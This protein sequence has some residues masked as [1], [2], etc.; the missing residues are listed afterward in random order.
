MNADARL[1]ARQ[2]RDFA[3]ATG[4][5]L[6]ALALALP[7]ARADD[8]AGPAI[9]LTVFPAAL[10]FGDVP[11]GAT[12]YR[13]MWVQNWNGAPVTLGTLS[14]PAPFAIQGDTCSGQTL[15]DG[16]Y[17]LLTAVFA[18][19]AAGSFAGTFAVPTTVPAG[20]QVDVP[21]SGTAAVSVDGACGSASASVLTAAPASALCSAGVASAVYPSASDF[22]WNCAGAGGGGTASCSAQRGYVVTP[23]AGSNGSLS[24]STPQVVAYGNSAVFAI[25]PAPGYDAL[26]A[27]TCGGVDTGPDYYTDAV[28]ADCTVSATFFAMPRL[29]S[30]TV[31][32]PGGKTY[33]DPPFA[34]QGTSSSGLPVEYAALTPTVCT[35]SGS[36][37]SLGMPGT[38]EIAANQGGDAQWLPAPTMLLVF[39]VAR[40][41][42]ALWFEPLADRYLS[43]SPAPLHAIGGV[44][45]YPVAFDSLTP[46]TCAVA[47]SSVT[48]LAPGACTVQASQAGDDRYLPAAI[49]RTFAIYNDER[50]DTLAFAPVTGV[51]LATLVVSDPVIVTGIDYPV[52]VTVTNGE[53]SVGCDGRFGRE[54]A[55]ILPNQR[56]CVRQLSAAT[57]FTGNTTQVSVGAARAEFATTTGRPEPRI[58]VLASR[59]PSLYRA[60]VVFTVQAGGDFG[61]VTG[62]VSLK[63]GGVAVLGCEAVALVDQRG[64]CRTDSL[65]PG[66]RELRARYEGND[67]YAWSE[68]VPRGHYVRADFG[69]DFRD[70]TG[71]GRSALF[72]ETARGGL[73]A[74]TV[75]RTVAGEVTALVDPD[76][77]WHAR[78]FADFDGDGKADVAMM[79]ADGSV[80]IWLLDGTT[81][82]RKGPLVEATGQIAPVL[83]GDFDGDGKD[84][85]VMRDAQGLYS[86]WLMDGLQVKSASA[87]PNAGPD[88]VP[89]AVADFDGD[90]HQD[91]VLRHADGR[92]RIQ[93]VK[94][95]LAREPADFDL[96]GPGFALER[97]GDFNGDN[98]ADLLLRG[99][100]GESIAW[101]MDGT[102]LER[103]LA[104]GEPTD[105]RVVHVADFD[106]DGADD[107]LLA[108]PGG[109]LALWMMDGLRVDRVLVIREPGEVAPWEVSTADATS[110]APAK[111]K[112]WRLLRVA[113]F[114]GDGRP[115]LMLQGDTGEIVVVV[116]DG[117]KVAGWGVIAGPTDWTII[118]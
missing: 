30:L 60:D 49:Q 1:A 72:L 105:W 24:P 115:D 94:D 104:I 29:Q 35:V 23:W 52:A 27:G 83:V 44:S 21:M 6:L 74:I 118:P 76:S 13:S 114:C 57:P 113:D 117:A 100:A 17:C 39:E 67:T 96:P 59:H 8:K 75:D 111:P 56:L 68:S 55:T 108:G 58:E 51:R 22:S 61:P 71:T 45:G 9:N 88:L 33:G 20:A 37:A 77:G 65:A 7:A 79:H 110:P 112:S 92:L 48:T 32:A 91:L 116:L 15:G 5:L 81:K 50:P 36:V 25:H 93:P 31:P 106:T 69:S 18:P 73:Q 98:K 109:G 53:F 99:P 47:G 103:A 40:A 4:W 89:V 80:A 102:R 12:G 43:P 97:I 66:V 70:I 11:V 90:G 63:H 16:Q 78:L 95:G 19:T 46:A 84:D 34:L 85:L 2:M 28:T 86:L 54:A 107:I 38:C 41:P 62:T 101:Q 42:Q 87:L 82:A 64:E 26:F 3:L 10:D 14:A